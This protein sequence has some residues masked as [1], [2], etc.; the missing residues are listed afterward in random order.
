MRA[1][2]NKTYLWGFL[3]GLLAIAS[4]TGTT[5]LLG[6]S[7]YLGT[8]TSFV[9]AAG[10]I[11]DILSTGAA[12]SLSYYVST[13]IKVDWQFMLVIGIAIGAFISSIMNRTFKI[14]W[15]PPVWRERFGA[16][17]LKRG[18]I[19]FVAGM[20][21]M[22]GVRLADG[23]PSGHGLSGM[24]QLSLSSLVSLFLFFALGMIAAHFVYSRR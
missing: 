4:A 24:M 13:K 17:I 6:K 19:A 7:N 22:Y 14:E 2:F 15:I 8:S 12:T 23:C 21:A 5:L 11:E 20:I 9:R 1:N 10:F 3:L 16:S 18:A